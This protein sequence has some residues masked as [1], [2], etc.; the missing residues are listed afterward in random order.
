[1]GTEENLQFWRNRE[2]SLVASSLGL[3]NFPQLLSAFL[4]KAMFELQWPGLSLHKL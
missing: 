2:K 4:G 3:S 1:M